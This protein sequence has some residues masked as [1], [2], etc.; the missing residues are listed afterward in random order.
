M[1]AEKRE[2]EIMSELEQLRKDARA[3]SDQVHELTSNLTNSKGILEAEE[4]KYWGVKLRSVSFV[5]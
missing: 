3:M 2:K 5:D 1:D 4:K